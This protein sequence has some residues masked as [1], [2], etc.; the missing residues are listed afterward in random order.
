[1][2]IP[3]SS[4]KLNPALLVMRKLNVCGSATG[5]PRE[6]QQML[7]FAAQHKIVAQ[8]E[9]FD[10]TEVNQALTKVRAN[11]VRYRAVLRA[12]L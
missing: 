5:S 11:A 2:G 12:K 7:E 10:L 4:V 3:A 1:M 9:L 8:T 6:M